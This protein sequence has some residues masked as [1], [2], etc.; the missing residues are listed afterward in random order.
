MLVCADRTRRGRFI[1]VWPQMWFLGVSEY[2][3]LYF[4]DNIFAS[5][6][7]LLQ[8]LLLF[9]QRYISYIISKGCDSKAR[10]WWYNC[11]ASVLFY[12]VFLSP[13][14]F[15][16]LFQPTLL[17]PIAPDFH[18]EFRCHLLF[19]HYPQTAPVQRSGTRFVLCLRIMEPTLNC[20]PRQVQCWPFGQP[21]QQ[22]CCAGLMLALGGLHVSQY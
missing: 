12:P 13:S 9:A 18:L 4:P 22:R 16:P 7:P 20:L 19:L 21:S 5:L 2:K 1:A 3:Y 11:C 15:S 10:L 17:S 6:V 14:P 8:A